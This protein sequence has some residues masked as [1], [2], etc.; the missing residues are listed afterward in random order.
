VIA[1]VVLIGVAVGERDNIATVMA[2]V[3]LIGVA[4]GERDNIATVIANV[5]LIG[6]AVGHL[7][8]HMYIKVKEH[9]R[10]SNIAFRHKLK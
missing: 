10:L 3:V 8:I 6:V 9:E 1:N 7:D 4:V 2:N 5:V